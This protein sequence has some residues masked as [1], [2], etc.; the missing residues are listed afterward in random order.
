M[1]V[2]VDKLM[3]KWNRPLINCTKYR[4]NAIRW[5]RT[6]WEN[7]PELFI[8]HW[9]ISLNGINK[10]VIIV[11]HTGMCH[12]NRPK[13]L[14]CCEVRM[15]VLGCWERF[16]ELCECDR[17][18]NSVRQ[19]QCSSLDIVVLQESQKATTILFQSIF[20]VTVVICYIDSVL[21]QTMIRT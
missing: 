8:F 21:L 20:L 1:N 2:Y 14:F 7:N 9:L 17:L 6:F 16:P 10:E 19:C 3:N 12:A 18:G 13:F 5:L 15:K 11:I 4:S